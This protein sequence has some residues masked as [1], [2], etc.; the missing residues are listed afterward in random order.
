MTRKM[1]KS[2]HDFKWQLSKGMASGR[3]TTK[4]KGDDSLDKQKRRKET[5]WKSLELWKGTSKTKR[6]T[7]NKRHGHIPHPS[8]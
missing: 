4:G 2:T 7:K 5:N 3:G 1:L 8:A 6:L